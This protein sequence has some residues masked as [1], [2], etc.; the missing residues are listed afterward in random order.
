[1]EKAEGSFAGGRR[2]R[3]RG[4]GKGKGRRVWGDGCGATGVQTRR[5]IILHAQGTP[6]AWVGKPDRSTG[7]TMP[8]AQC[9]IFINDFTKKQ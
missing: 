3:E 1:M 2:E 9:P 4:K 8:D 5:E 6:D 7:A